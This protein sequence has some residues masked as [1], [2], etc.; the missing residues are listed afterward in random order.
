LYWAQALAKQDK[1]AEL[2]AIFTPIA[3]DLSANEA[4]INEE[5]IAAQGKRQEIGGYYHPNFELTDKAMRPS[6]TFNGI[7]AKLK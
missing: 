6:A 7:L 1:D 4:K 5:L 3:T 2:K